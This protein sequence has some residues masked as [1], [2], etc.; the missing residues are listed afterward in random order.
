MRGMLGNMVAF[1][2]FN[3]QLQLKGKV[4]LVTGGNGGIGLG[5]AR[6]LAQ[7]GATVVVAGRDAAKNAA[8][9]KRAR[10]RL[11]AKA[12]AIAVDVAEGRRRAARWSTDA[13][14][15][16]RPARHPGQQR[17]HQHPQ[18]A[19]RSYTLAEWHAGD[20]HQ[21]HQRLPVLPGRLSRR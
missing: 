14:K 4:A 1:V 16:H 7:A 15:A 6:G 11:G 3:G 10:R 9:V 12:S 21:P 8:A 20:R 5:M 2:K 18:A 13:V 17:R 19:A